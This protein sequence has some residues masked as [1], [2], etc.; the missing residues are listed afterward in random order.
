MLTLDGTQIVSTVFPDGTKQI[1]KLNEEL[2][3]P[4]LPY[5]ESPAHIKWA[6]EN[7]GEL[8]ELAQLKVLLD[9]LHR[10]TKLEIEYLPYARQDKQVS[11]DA[12]FGLYPFALLL[13]TMKFDDIVILDT[14]SPSAIQA[15]VGAR[16][17]YPTLLVEQVILDNGIDILCFPDHGAQEKYAKMYTGMPSVF[18]NKIREQSTGII[19]ETKL[20]GSVEGQRVLI[21]DDICD[22]GATF[23]SLAKVL[24]EN[25]ATYVGLYVTHGIFSKGIQVLL[26]AG[27]DKVSYTHRQG[28]IK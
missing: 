23:T 26:D 12:T 17:Y 14:H 16:T 2:L 20:N 22:G 24:K 5:P 11:N 1:W 25:G 7:D 10:K 13:N 4:A 19:L 27:I 18:A 21:I 3:T 8:I 6:Y 15:I 9:S 28:E